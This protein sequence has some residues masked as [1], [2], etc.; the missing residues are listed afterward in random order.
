MSV[1]GT[2]GACAASQHGVFHRRQARSAG[3]TSRQIEWAL[4]TGEISRRAPE[5]YAVAG[6]P[7]TWRQAL[8]VAVLDAGPDAAVS[9]RAAA[10]L[11]GMARRDSPELVEI[12]VPRPASA[13]LANVVA[14][15]SLDLRPDHL[16]VVDGMP[17]TGPL[18][19]LVDLGAV[20]P[21]PVVADALERALQSGAVSLRGAE[22]ML[23]NLSR[24]GRSGCG[25]FR[26]VL[27]ERV[28]RS[29][30]PDPG[31]LEPRMLRLLRQS[32]LPMPE[33]QYVVRDA[34]GLFVARVDFAFPARRE[35]IEVDGFEVHGT[36]AAM[37]ADFERAH[38][39]RR[40]GWHVTRFSW[41]Q[42]VRRPQHVI[43][44]IRTILGADSHV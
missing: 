30:A 34:D 28:L 13:R 15:R 31:L 10:T 19:T 22:W 2:L 3:L 39:L 18:R 32:G 26:R 11:L 41:D 36:P 25:V 42:V 17:C 40:V 4:A 14:H 9:H 29:A 24:R 35:A 44:T 20:E 43:Q 1:V 16:L 27:D 8:M 21:W 23:T 38:R 37:A 33:Y 12:S 7:R 5:V 6:T